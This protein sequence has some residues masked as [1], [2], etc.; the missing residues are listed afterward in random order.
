MTVSVDDLV[1][2]AKQA[3]EA[4]M[5][6]YDGEIAVSQKEDESPLTLADL[7]ADRIICSGLK[8]LYPEI[9]ILSEESASGE[10]ADYDNFFL[11]DPLDG[12]KE[13]LKRNGEFT[14]NIAWI[15]NGV[16]EVAVVYVPALEECYK[17]DASGA[18]EEQDDGTWKKL[19]SKKSAGD[20]LQIVGSRS[21]GAEEMEKWLATLTVPYEFLA[22]GSS[23]KFC[24]VAQGVADVYPRFGPTCQWDTAAA[25]C[26]VEKAGGTVTDLNGVRLHYG[27]LREKL[28]P[29]FICKN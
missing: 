14:V 25:Q 4:I 17:A 21:H 7:E 5:K 22:V 20:K 1:V 3:G 10:L 8:K 11:V 29:Y 23:L 18:F 15:K 24:R 13:F 27:V 12:T 26:I 2:I 28:N 6:I 19:E 9:F 16:A